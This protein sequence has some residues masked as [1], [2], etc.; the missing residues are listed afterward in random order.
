M[1]RILRQSSVVGAFVLVMINQNAFSQ[2]RQFRFQH[3]NVEQGLSAS[4]VYTITQDKHGFVWLGTT[5]G[6]NRFDGKNV[7]VFRY[8]IGDRNSLPNNSVLSLFTD[9]RGIVWIGLPNGLARYDEHTNSFRSF[10]DSPKGNNSPAG[11]V[12][13]AINE[14]SRGLL[15]IGTPQGLYSF[16]AKKNRFERFLHDDHSDNSI[17]SN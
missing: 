12:I 11:N 3:L 9:S 10:I 2:A 8:K 16:D 5:D 14:D 17:S 15:W 7:E 6:L 13:N 4:L 1:K